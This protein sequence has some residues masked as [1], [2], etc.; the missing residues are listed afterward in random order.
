MDRIFQYLYYIVLSA[1]LGFVIYLTA[2][3]YISPRQDAQERGFIPCT[4]EL[5]YE[6]SGCERGKLGCAAKHLWRDMKCNV[7][8]I[9]AGAKMWIKGEQTT[10]WANYLFEPILEAKEVQIQYIGN[11]TDDMQN[12]EKQYFSV[13]QKQRELEAA[14]HRQFNIDLDVI[15][16]DPENYIPESKT[17]PPSAEDNI[18]VPS[19]DIAE[20]ADIDMKAFTESTATG[21]NNVAPQEK[22]VLKT[23]K[24]KTDDKLQKG[25]LKDEK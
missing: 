4:K 19:G 22:D 5:V 7:G 21:N 6:L 17:L 25:N 2:M 20:E 3:L 11:A 9:Y 8:V 12:T 16:T 15:A 1:L 10:P 14:K 18:D 24:S 23:L 13:Q